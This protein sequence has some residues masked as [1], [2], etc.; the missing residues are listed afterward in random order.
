LDNLRK[1]GKALV[2]LLALKIN[3]IT[4]FFAGTGE[5]PW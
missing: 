2:K 3:A 4:K 1:F 5:I